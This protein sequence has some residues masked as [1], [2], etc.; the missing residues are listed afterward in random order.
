M[1]MPDIFQIFTICLTLL[2]ASTA[3]AD[4][5]PRIVGGEESAENA[6]PFMSALMFKN[7]GITTNTDESF[8]AFFMEGTPSKDF[9]GVLANCDQAFDACEAV[10]NKICLI[11]RGT[12]LFTEKIAN[13]ELGGGLAAIIYNNIEG[14][15]LGQAEANI[16]AVSVS[17]TSGLAL[18]NHLNEKIHF[19]FLDDIPTFSFC[20]GSYIG[21]KWVVTAAHCIKEVTAP[22]ITL[23]IGG[24]DLK[25]DQENVIDVA[26]IYI[27][28]DY[29][30]D[31]LNNDIALIELKSAPKGVTP[32]LIANETITNL[33]T[34]SNA[35]V[36]TIGRGTQTPQGIL[37]DPEPEFPDSR[38]FEVNLS[39]VD[40]Q[41][42]NSIMGNLIDNDMICAGDLAGG[43]GSCKGDSGGPLILQQPDETYLVGITSWGFGCAQADYYGVYGR[44]TYFKSSIDA[45]INGAPQ[46]SF[47]S[48][49]PEKGGGGS[50]SVQIILLWLLSSLIIFPTRKYFNQSSIK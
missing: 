14:I 23:N 13:C 5:Q 50:L 41:T 8:R 35:E 32:I 31:T 30:T 25:I 37:E 27:H 36:T 7:A 22:S 1:K 48:T 46:G 33:A 10:S 42:C 28:K 38:L 29:D 44:V 12:T 47:I 49:T 19:G 40:N 43:V 39:L 20:G 11:E 17:R 34:E 3:Y 45:L 16:P 18:L 24:H 26:N 6:W 2:I 21:G 15:F 9:S 4:I